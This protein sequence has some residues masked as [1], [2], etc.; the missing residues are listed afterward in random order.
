MDGAGGTGGTGWS[1]RCAACAGD[2]GGAAGGSIFVVKLA[3]FWITSTI[4]TAT[5]TSKQLHTISLNNL[6]YIY[7]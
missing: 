5:H 7:W 6:A 3:I 1:C 2:T 4:H